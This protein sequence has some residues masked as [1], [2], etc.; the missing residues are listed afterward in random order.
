MSQ[1]TQEKPCD[2][3]KVLSSSLDL[4]V[5]SIYACP[6]GQSYVLCVLKVKAT[7]CMTLRWFYYLSFFPLVLLN[8]MIKIIK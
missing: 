8:K 1:K 4:D 7:T 2:L 5:Q 3:I 6:W